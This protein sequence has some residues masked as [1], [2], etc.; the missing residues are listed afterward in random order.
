MLLRRITEHVQAQNW[1]AI[2]ID[3]VIV[4]VGVF[5]GIQVSNW[6]DVRVARAMEIEFL[7]TV[8]DDIQQDIADS[9]GFV[10]MLAGVSRYGNLVLEV[11]DRDSECEG[12]CWLELLYFFHASQWIDVRTDRSTFDEIK[13]TGL[14]RDA[15][16]KATLTR[17]YGLT[18][19]VTIIVSELPAYRTLVRSK[20]P[21][22]VQQYMWEQCIGIDGR[23]QILND[24][25]E[26]PITEHEA[27]EIVET[28]R[29][30]AHA[31]PVSYTHLTLPTTSRV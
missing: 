10:D 27:R 4:V 12:N 22:D 1:V 20:I 24:D 28:L 9:R 31:R 29:G 2:G 3:F 18:D 7:G 19:Q 6:N 5:I 23:Q 8:R 15:G 25:C 21:A 17:Y 26:S 13:R 14:P 16:L 30:D 11:I